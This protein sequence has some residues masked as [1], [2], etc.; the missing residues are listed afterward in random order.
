MVVDTSALVALFLDEPEREAFVD[1]IDAAPTAGVSVASRLEAV[2]VLCGRRIRADPD[3]VTGFID[4]LHLDVEPVSL[5]QMDLAID[6]LLRFGR[7]RHP[8][9]L[10][11]GD[12]FAYALAKAR[13]EPLL[14]KGE[15]FART[16]IAPA[17]RP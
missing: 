1:L 12:G 7:G 4:A 16:D 2:S 13:D 5:A 17:W 9:A 10:N 15:D 14:Y 3:E 8:V 6:A 11:F